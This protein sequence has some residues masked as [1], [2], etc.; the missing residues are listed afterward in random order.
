MATPAF[1]H[2]QFAALAHALRDGQSRDE[3]YDIVCTRAV[4]L[5]DGVDR[6]AIAMRQG[7]RFVG[8]AATDD[9]MRMIDRLQDE[10]DEGPCF[11]ASIDEKV[12]VD[13]DITKDSA[14]PR[15]AERVVRETPVRAMLAVPLVQDGARCGALNLFADS[16]DVFTDESIGQGAILGSMASVAIWGAAHAERAE[17]LSEGMV[18]N[19][20]IGAAVGILMA[21][22]GISQD[23][24]FH[25]LATA[26]QRLNRKLRDIAGGIVRGDTAPGGA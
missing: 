12:H 18:T 11:E 1:A 5:V 16:P 26:S 21:T 14:W 7:E 15:L 24:A 23:D 13:N 8:V 22:H 20:E 2:D 19:R 25:L 4:D 6:A 3:V 17:Q 9:I 10:L